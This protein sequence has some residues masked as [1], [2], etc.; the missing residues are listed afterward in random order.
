VKKLIQILLLSVVASLL[1]STLACSK[2]DESHTVRATAPQKPAAPNSSMPALDSHNTR[3]STGISNDDTANSNKPKLNRHKD[4]LK[5]SVSEAS[6]IR[7]DLEAKFDSQADSELKERS[8]SLAESIEDVRISVMRDT[9]IAEISV[10]LKDNKSKNLQRFDLSGSLD[11]DSKAQL[12]ANLSTLR[13]QVRG[14]LQCLDQKVSNCQISV[15]TFK[16]MGKE[17]AVAQ[18]LI[19]KT[20]GTLDYEPSKQYQISDAKDV[21]QLFQDTI[22][23]KFEGAAIRS[24][25]NTIEV[26]KGRSIIDV[27]MVTH[28]N[29]VLGFHGPL[30]LPDPSAT[31]TN[32]KMEKSVDE[33]LLSNYGDVGS[34]K[35]NLQDS[36]Q[37]VRLIEIVANE[38]FSVL[39]TFNDGNNSETI[40]FYLYRQPV[41]TKSLK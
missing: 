10:T 17:K 14:E 25:V 7:K 4:F 8:V 41:S 18:V 29:Q 13:N 21:A 11:T 15:L 19:R 1:L 27:L 5:F 2:K 36:I 28:D 40:N 6:K 30:L 26:I 33:M 9:G 38:R 37:D 32:V 22:D 12:R 34:F 3:G 31:I 16:K 23:F 20:A 35:R 24:M 39:Y